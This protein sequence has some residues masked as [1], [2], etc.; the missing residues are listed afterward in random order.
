M[1]KDLK[2]DHFVHPEC[3]MCCICKKYIETTNAILL[4]TGQLI[5]FKCNKCCRCKQA[6]DEKS[7]KYQGAHMTAGYLW[8]KN[9]FKCSVRVCIYHYYEIIFVIPMQ[10]CYRP[11]DHDGYCLK[12]GVI[13]L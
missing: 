12:C 5:C 2:K 6:I 3:Y 8:H 4:D 1:S 9:C 10:A 11:L 7:F 13:S